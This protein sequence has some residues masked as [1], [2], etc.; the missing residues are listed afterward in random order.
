[1][2]KIILLTTVLCNTIYC[3]AQKNVEN[4]DFQQLL[5]KFTTIQ[6]PVNYKK[7][8]GGSPWMSKKEAIHFFHKKEHELYYIDADMGEDET[9]TRTKRDITPACVFKYN[10]S[11]SMYILCTVESILGKGVDTN[12][13]RLNSFTLNGR[14]T[15]N[16]IVGG[17]F[18]R[19]AD[20]VT[21]VLLNKNII[22]VYYYEDTEKDEGFRSKA[23]YCEYEITEKGNYIFKAKS[24]IYYL[25]QYANA[26]GTYKPKS[27]DPMNVYD[28]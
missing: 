13:V 2:K 8:H 9:I 15:D 6:P 17:F 22:R 18:T 3:N 4:K 5:D 23:Y 20:M 24:E 26:Y 12:I 21:F 27:D 19:D 1:M 16:C 25:K 7:L 28:F 11:D 10:L 14:H